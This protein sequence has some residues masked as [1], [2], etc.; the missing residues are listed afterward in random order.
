MSARLGFFC[1]ACFPVNECRLLICVLFLIII[2]I[3][4][5]IFDILFPGTNRDHIQ[6]W[7]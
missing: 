2:I 3:L 6:L 1:F 4:I 5:I 7:P